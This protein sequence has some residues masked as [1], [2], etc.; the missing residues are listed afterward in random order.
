MHEIV[1]ESKNRLIR[2]CLVG[3]L[4][5][6]E[7]EAFDASM[8]RHVREL[9]VKGGDFDVLA[10]LRR[11]SVMPQTETQVASGQMKWLVEAGLR[12]AAHIMQSTLLVLQMK[13][14]A[15]D[16]RFA[17]FTTEEDALHWLD[18]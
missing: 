13:R 4:E 9:T 17:Y 7:F 1:V 8:R 5:R 12:K 11:T 6:A 15:N 10:D 18:K 3:L 14:L 16:E 2:F